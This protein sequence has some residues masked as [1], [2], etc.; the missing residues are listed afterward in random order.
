MDCRRRGTASTGRTDNAMKPTN[1]LFILSDEHQHNL[2]GCAGHPLIKTPSLDALA[3]RG[4]RFKNAYT[5]SPI[6]V[7]ARASLA[8][9]RYVHDIR[10]WD[11]A[12]AYD[13]STPGWAQHLSTSGVLTESIGKLHYKSDAS[14]VGFRRQ[15]HAVHILDGIGQVWGSVR[16]PMPDTMGRSPLYDKIG[17]GTS[18]Y[19]RFDMR[20]AD[21]ACGWLGE[22]AADDKPWVLF[23]GLVAPH[24]PLVVPQD[25][26]DLY[27][28]R[29]IDLPLL[30]PSTGYVRHPW[31]QRQA[32]HMDHDAAIGSDE[33]RRLA[34]ACYYALVSFLDAQVG[35]VLAALRASGLDDSTTIIYSSDHGDNLG[36]RGMWNKCLMYRESTG[37]PMIVAGPGIPA[38]KVSETPVSLIDIQ[39]TLLEC[40]GCEA[41][42]IDGPGES[43]VELACA[44]DDV[45][46]LAF[47]EYHAVGSES[48]AYMLADSRYKYHH[49]LGMKPE[50]FDVKT[51]PEEMRDLASLPEYADVLAH[52]ERQ[53]RALLDPETTDAAAKADQ[54][55]LVEAFG[56]REAA[57]RTG[58]PAATP[59]PVE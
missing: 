20:V 6:C 1:V 25:F 37:V 26:L 24:F 43:L 39:N 51:D 46:R 27:D 33:R 56:G 11:N 38:S 18:D 59:V 30:H 50:L 54:D 58:T 12:I 42:L 28:P 3:Q 19:N 15:Q 7:P 21:T 2:M 47:S 5:P 10:C 8:T 22:H 16:N 31:V 55:R 29:E 41:A 44:E 53:L 4:T 35:K 17:P 48:A 34:V 36:K 13:G 14:P 9:G 40:T 23:V 49:Y 57:L 45:G 52:F 32:R